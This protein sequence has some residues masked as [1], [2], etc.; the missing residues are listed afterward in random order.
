MILK[1]GNPIFPSGE[2]RRYDSR[3]E[4][5]FAHDGALGTPCDS[6]AAS[7]ATPR[8]YGDDADDGAEYLELDGRIVWERPSRKSN[9]AAP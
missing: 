6:P 7:R 5:H 9:A 4:E 1:T 2:P 8:R 3:L